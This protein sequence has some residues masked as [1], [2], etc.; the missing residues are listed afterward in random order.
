M[1]DILRAVKGMNDLF[2][3]ELATWRKVEDAARRTFLAF[4]Y[5]E[6]RTPIVEETALFVRG[7]GEGTDIVDKEMYAFPDGDKNLSLRPEGTAGV[8]RAMIEHGKLAADAEERVFYLGAMFRRERPQKGRYRQFHQFGAEALG[9]TAASVDVEMMA[10]IAAFLDDLGVTG[11]QLLVNTLGD[12]EDRARYGAAL[13]DHFSKV[14]GE[15]S[16]DSQRRLQT[17]V[18]RILDSK[19]P[20]DQALAQGAPRT[21]DHLGDDARAHF[22]QVQA[23]L[24]RLGIPFVVEPKLVRGLDYYTRT[25]FEAQAAQGLGA[26]NTVAA[27]GRYD[28]LVETLGGRKTP[29]VGFAGGMERLILL[30][31]DAGKA[32]AEPGA[33]LYLGAADE[34]GRAAA[35]ARTRSGGVA[36]ASRST[37]GAAA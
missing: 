12:P 32:A 18:L 36:S 23:G 21:L 27:G 25:V 3:G 2:E 30:L 20:K 1:V 6:V 14:A 10:M 8:V 37:T 29:A 19:D 28:G 26:Q 11:V 31:Q 13:R 34:S 15:L 5:G 16:A 33:T 4:G 35:G 9:L 17:N 22:D 7:V 24:T